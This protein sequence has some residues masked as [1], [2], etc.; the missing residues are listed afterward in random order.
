[1]ESAQLSEHMLPLERNQD[2]IENDMDCSTSEMLL[3]HQV[4]SVKTHCHGPAASEDRV[5]RN[6]LIAISVL[7]FVFMV[8]EVIGE[9]FLLKNCCYSKYVLPMLTVFS[10]VR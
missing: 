4:P 5:A 6:Q 2:S 9:E 3:N 1:M 8:A 10:G 7:C